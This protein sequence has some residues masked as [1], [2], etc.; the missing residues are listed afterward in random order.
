MF[1]VR[2]KRG[3]EDGLF[4]GGVAGDS[5]GSVREDSEGHRRRRSGSDG[6]QVPSG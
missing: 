2:Y 3:S 1:L 5:G 4:G 6:G